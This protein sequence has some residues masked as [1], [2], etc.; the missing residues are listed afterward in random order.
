ML[1]TS[2]HFVSDALY[3]KH[4]QNAKNRKVNCANDTSIPWKAPPPT[5]SSSPQHQASEALT[6][7]ENDSEW[8]GAITIGS[9]K[10][11]FVIDFDTGSADLWVP[12]AA[13]CST[14]AGK[15]VYDATSS[16]S[17]K[18]KSGTFS[19]SYGDGSSVHGPIFTDTGVLFVATSILPA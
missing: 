8:T 4:N 11:P 2:P 17:S 18:G 3:S 1:A 19:I 7:Q 15:H 6:D 10:Q 14:C 5:K 16:T 9:N 13:G 12:N